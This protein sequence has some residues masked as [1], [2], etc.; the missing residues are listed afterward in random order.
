MICRFCSKI[1]K[2]KLSLS[3]HES[4]CPSNPDRVYVNGMTGKKA[5]NKGL[6]KETDQR[7]KRY[8]ENLSTSMKGK[9]T[10]IWDDD[11]RTKQSIRMKRAVQEHPESYSYDNVAGRVKLFDVQSSDGL[12]K[13]RGS[14]EYK[15]ANHLNLK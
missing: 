15:V 3:T 10:W 4:K 9:S 6:S 14:W 12:T 5:W 1:C 11:A 2:N 8:A 13:V 7:I